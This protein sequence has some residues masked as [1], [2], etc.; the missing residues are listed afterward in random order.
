M[1]IGEPLRRASLRCLPL[2]RLIA[3]VVAAGHPLLRCTQLHAD[4]CCCCCAQ[5][6]IT[7]PRGSR[8]AGLSRKGGILRAGG[9]QRRHQWR[10]WSVRGL[11][12]ERGGVYSFSRLRGGELGAHCWGIGMGEEEEW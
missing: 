2:Q 9:C 3:L 5:L 10:W 7:L 11:G 12:W 8:V 6:S 1:V 4:R